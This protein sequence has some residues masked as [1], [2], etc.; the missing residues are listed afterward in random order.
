MSLM[1]EILHE[2]VKLKLNLKTSGTLP[3]LRFIGDFVHQP[4][5]YM[6]IYVSGFQDTPPKE[7]AKHLSANT[8]IHIYS[9]IET[10]VHIYI[11]I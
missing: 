6:Y 8:Y 11:Y 7:N 1:D 9:Y 3:R 4:Y 2:P 5:M 10:H